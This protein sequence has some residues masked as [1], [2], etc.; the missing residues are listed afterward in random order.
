MMIMF[1]Q[2]IVGPDIFSFN[3]HVNNGI[4]S[5]CESHYGRNPESR[6]GILVKT[7]SVC[8]RRP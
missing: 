2:G 8:R 7:D 1:R 3:A 4:R 5:H 6:D